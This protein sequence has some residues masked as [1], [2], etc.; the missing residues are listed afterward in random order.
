MIE[1]DDLW[2]A[3]GDNEVL[4]GISLRIPPGTTFV[5]TGG[6]MGAMTARSV[7]GVY[8]AAGRP[9]MELF[10]GVVSGLFVVRSVLSK[11]TT[12]RPTSSR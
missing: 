5:G 4:K 6:G 7:R 12:S 11:Q 2:K 1:V 9:A 8:A 3:F 10:S